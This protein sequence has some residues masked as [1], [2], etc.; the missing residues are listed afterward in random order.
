MEITH[1]T[2]RIHCRDFFGLQLHRYRYVTGEG[3]RAKGGGEG[4]SSG[5]KRGRE[6]GMEQAK[7]G[8]REGDGGAH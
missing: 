8:E 5:R 7:E 6:R 1:S 3:R 2:Q 4:V